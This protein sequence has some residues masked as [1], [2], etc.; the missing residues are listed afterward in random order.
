M[1]SILRRRRALMAQAPSS[2]WT[3]ITGLTWTVGQTVT[4][5]GQN[6]TAAY[7]SRSG[8]VSVKKQPFTIRN[9][10]SMQDGDGYILNLAVHEYAESTW[11]R[12][13][14][15]NEQNGLEVVLGSDCTKS[16]FTLN[17]QSTSGKT[18][19]QSIID[20]YFGASYKEG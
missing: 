5:T 14:I 2:E 20:T 9:T 1:N 16:R 6:T 3:P 7:G 15:L 18:M 13:K 10:G 11:K 4:S 8:Y 17:Y 12:R 19:T